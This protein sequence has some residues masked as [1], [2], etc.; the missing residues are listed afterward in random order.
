MRDHGSLKAVVK[1]LRERQADKVE[2]EAVK[3]EA[4]SEPEEIVPESEGE[5][6]AEVAGSERGSSPPVKA[7]T[8]GKSR[9]IVDL[10][11]DSDASD[12][13]FAA[14]ADESNSDAGEDE[15]PAASSSKTKAAPRKKTSAAAKK[16]APKKRSNNLVI[17]DDWPWE[18]ARQLFLKPDVTPAKDVEVSAIDDLA[19]LCSRQLTLPSP[20]SGRV[21]AARRRRPRP[22]PRAREGLQVRRLHCSSLRRL[23][24]ELTT[25]V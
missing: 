4:S 1:H 21:D 25:A 23:R 16:A 8:K 17:P 7:A 12:R 6:P 20:L 15:K 9:R 10:D 19:A 2:E 3:A 5:D 11:E 14:P 24:S 18:E 13:E 22:V